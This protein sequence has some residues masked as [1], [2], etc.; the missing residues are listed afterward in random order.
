MVRD[1]TVVFIVEFYARIDEMFMLLCTSGGETVCKKGALRA[2]GRSFPCLTAVQEE[3]WCLEGPS[4][5]V[6]Y[7]VPLCLAVLL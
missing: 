1:C 7:K 2:C 5:A 4:I 3:L 6:R